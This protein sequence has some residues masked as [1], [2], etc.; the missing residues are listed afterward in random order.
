MKEFSSAY[1]PMRL[2][3]ERGSRQFETDVTPIL[4]DKSGM[5]YSGWSEKGQTEVGPTSRGNAGGEGGAQKRA[6]SW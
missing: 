6:T 5:A 3:V 4:D 2:T 1:H